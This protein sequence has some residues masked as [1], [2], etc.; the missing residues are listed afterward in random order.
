M[1]KAAKQILL[2]IATEWAENAAENFEDLIEAQQTDAQLHALY[3]DADY[4]KAKQL[5]D[6]WFAIA[7]CKARP[8]RKKT[9]M[10]N[11]EILLAAANLATADR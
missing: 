2:E 1:T 7:H 11:A 9:M 3:G 4:E 10:I 5:R 8:R 6:A